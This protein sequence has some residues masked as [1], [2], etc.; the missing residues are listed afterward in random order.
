MFTYVNLCMCVCGVAGISH[1][2][3]DILFLSP[4]GSGPLCNTK[5]TQSNFKSLHNPN[6]S[7]TVQK[8]KHCLE[9]KLER[10]LSSYEHWLYFQRIQHSH[11][12]SPLSVS[13]VSGDPTPSHRHI[14]RQNT[15]VLYISCSEVLRTPWPGLSQQQINHLAPIFYVSYLSYPS[16]QAT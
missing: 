15:N 5:H 16:D 13:P 1:S 3:N 9:S 10:W 14:F 7:N 12:R 11:G 4:I 6:S 8:L 2:R